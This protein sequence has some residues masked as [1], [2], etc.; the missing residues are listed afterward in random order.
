MAKIK[1]AFFLDVMEEDFD[2]VSV[3]MHQVI[4]RI[5][6]SEFEVIFITP[7]PPKKELPYP[8]HV[9]PSIRVPE[10]NKEY[11]F[12]L[13]KRMKELKGILDEFDPDIVHYS[14]PT[15]MG[16]YAEAYANRNGKLVI[17][18]YHTH[19]QSFTSYYFGYFSRVVNRLFPWLMAMYRRTDRILAPSSPMRDYLITLGVDEHSIGIWGR[20]VDTDRFSP[21]KREM[22]LWKDIPAA[23]KKVLFVSR[24]T[25]E[26]EP[27][28]LIR[29]YNLIEEKGAQ[30]SLIIVGDGPMREMLESHMPNAVF[31]G[32]QVGEDLSRAFASADMFVFPST[33]ETFGNVVL[34]ALAS[35]LPVVAANAGGPTD[36]VTDRENG[37]LVEPQNEHEFFDK[38]MLL[39]T[40]DLVR[41]KMSE[42][43]LNYAR[44]QS[45]EKLSKQ[46]FDEYVSLVS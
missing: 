38:L 16:K 28:T 6:T 19:Y 39:A 1:I 43:A 2:G 44:S 32:R 31:M 35:G 9:V 8:V 11:R 25:K 15:F 30:L 26:K 40:D 20:G 13:P 4:D 27:Q 24:L 12:G 18:I 7:H 23:N 45:W 41:Q 17:S 22:N 33:T 5:P 36:I 10:K 14:S 37:F 34:E 29:L 3:T 42:E 21:A 46:L